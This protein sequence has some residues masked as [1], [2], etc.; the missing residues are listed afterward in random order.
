MKELLKSC[1]GALKSCE[2]PFKNL[3][4]FTSQDLKKSLKIKKV[5]EILISRNKK[6]VKSISQDFRRGFTRFKEY[7]VKSF[8]RFYKRAIHKIL[9]VI[10]KKHLHKI[11]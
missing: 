7:L 10:F 5:F 3:V 8:T 6:V 11:L 4:K 9:V 2:S 1:E